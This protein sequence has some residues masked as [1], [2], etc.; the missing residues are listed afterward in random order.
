MFNF[1]DELRKKAPSSELL[2]NFNI[3]NMSGKLV[4]IEGH[5]GVTILTSEMIAFKIKKGRVVVEG[6]DL[7]LAELTDNTMTI[8]GTIKKMEQF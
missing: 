4:Y 3:V 6:E 7:K 5:Q 8:N 2:G 1:F